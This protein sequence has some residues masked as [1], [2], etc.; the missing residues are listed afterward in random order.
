MNLTNQSYCFSSS[1]V[2]MW[3]L[4]HKESWMPNIWCFWTVVLEQPLESPLDSKEIKRK[5]ALNIHWKDWCW[6]WSSNTLATWCEELTHWKRSW[7]WERLMVGGEGDGRGWD[8][9]MASLTQWTWV[10]AGSRV[11]NW[12]GSVACCSPWVRKEFYNTEWLNWAELN[13]GIVGYGER[14]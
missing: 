10:W 5:S 7:C 9:W 2:W 8:S 4:D 12:H 1:H 11:G 14:K 6:S 3:E 13:G